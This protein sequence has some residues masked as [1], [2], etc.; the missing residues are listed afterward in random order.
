MS[1]MS[2][3]QMPAGGDADP[4]PSADIVPPAAEP[5]GPPSDQADSADHNAASEPEV[6]QP[7]AGGALRGGTTGVDSASGSDPMPDMAGTDPD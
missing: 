7:S 3:A 5:E 4:D 6:D 1:E 2:Q